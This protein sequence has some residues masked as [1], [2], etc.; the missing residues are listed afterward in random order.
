MVVSTLVRLVKCTKKNGEI[1]LGII[2]TILNVGIFRLIVEHMFLG[3][4]IYDM[5]YA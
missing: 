4:T 5:I 3:Y 2:N 1:G